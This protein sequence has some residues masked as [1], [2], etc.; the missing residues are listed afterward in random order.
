M[1]FLVWFS[2]YPFLGG[3][4][5]HPISLIFIHHP[6]LSAPSSPWSRSCFSQLLLPIN[7]LSPC[8]NHWVGD[9]WCARKCKNS[10]AKLLHRWCDGSSYLHGQMEESSCYTPQVGGCSARICPA[11]SVSSVHHFSSFCRLELQ[12]DN[13]NKKY[14]PTW[15]T[16]NHMCVCI[17]KRMLLFCSFLI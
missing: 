13:E 17:V 14:I 1:S 15:H 8:T 2:P 11:Q 3:G 6:W 12:S 16:C 4:V 9:W 10:V 5:S 7:P